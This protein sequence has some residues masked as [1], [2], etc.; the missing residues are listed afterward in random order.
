[1]RNRIWNPAL[2]R[3]GLRHR[4]P[5]QTR[6]TF[7]SLMLDQN[8]DPAWVARM[9]GHTTLR[10]LYAVDL[11][12]SPPPAG[13]GGVEILVNDRTVDAG[14]INRTQ[15]ETSV[16]VLGKTVLVGFND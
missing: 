10:M 2:A 7:A 9:L 15:S 3:A 8:E 5:Y 14:K 16:A 4:N 1:M 13:S 11:S 6:H 12:L